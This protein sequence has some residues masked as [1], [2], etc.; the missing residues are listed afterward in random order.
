MHVYYVICMYAYYVMFYVFLA[1]PVGEY[2][3][4]FVVNAY[5]LMLWAHS[6]T[7]NGVSPDFSTGSP[8][9]VLSL[10]RVLCVGQVSSMPFCWYTHVSCPWSPRRRTNDGI[11]SVRCCGCHSTP[12][13]LLL[14][15]VVSLLP[16]SSGP[17][18]V[19]PS[20]TRS[21]WRAPTTEWFRPSS[22]ILLLMSGT[23]LRDSRA[24]GHWVSD[25]HSQSST[26]QH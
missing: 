25:G 18:A 4:S 24:Q 19:T 12:V 26:L 10:R 13:T 6:P 23:T 3:I 14:L 2:T 20:V 8:P 17:M 21:S 9:C 1:A 7:D 15:D 16:L 5:I 22:T 11:S